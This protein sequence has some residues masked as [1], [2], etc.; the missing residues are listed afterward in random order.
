M[1]AWASDPMTWGNQD[2]GEFPLETGKNALPKGL[3]FRLRYQ[4]PIPAPCYKLCD[5]GQSLGNPHL[6]G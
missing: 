1:R 6:K 5:L 4:F 3:K 2:S